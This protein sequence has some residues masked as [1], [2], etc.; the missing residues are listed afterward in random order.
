VLFELQ[1]LEPLRKQLLKYGVIE[2][3]LLSEAVEFHT[4]EL[5]EES[6][7]QSALLLTMLVGDRDTQ[8]VVVTVIT[9]GCGKGRKQLQ[10][11][12]KVVLKYLM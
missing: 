11:S 6:R 7:M 2:A 8:P 10:V 5:S 12:F 1:P 9:N 3:V 4:G